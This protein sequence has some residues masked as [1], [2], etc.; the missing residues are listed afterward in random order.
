MA[1]PKHIGGSRQMENN[2][3]QSTFPRDAELD[4][5]TLCDV[6]YHIFFISPFRFKF[7]EASNTYILHRSKFRQVR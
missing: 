1:C 2:N 6:H 4:L 3:K 5:K 7:N